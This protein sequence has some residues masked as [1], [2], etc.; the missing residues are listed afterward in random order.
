MEIITITLIAGLVL[1]A[2]ALVS[3]PLWQQSKQ[4]QMVLAAPLP[5]QTP[6]EIEARYQAT[7]A[8]IKDLMFDYEM[9]KLTHDDYNTL[10]VKSKTEA[11]RLRQMLD[12]MTFE[13]GISPE[14]DAQIEALIADTR[15]LPL[16]R[17]GNRALLKQIDRNIA[18][19]KSS[20]GHCTACPHCDGRVL[21]SDSFCPSCGLAL[22]NGPA[23]IATANTCQKCSAPVE[24]ADAY[25]AGC[26]AALDPLHSASLEKALVL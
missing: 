25:C 17:N 12:R 18:Q 13:S 2:L 20:N 3:Y 15:Q 4:H 16:N 5:G 26:G 9:G 11:A 8:S 22:N 1:A 19:L 10:L 6:R 23:T 21:L 24:P 7:L 14:V